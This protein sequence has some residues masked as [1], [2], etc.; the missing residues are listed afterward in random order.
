MELS[1]YVGRWVK[2][3]VSNGYYYQGLI[4]NVDEDSVTLRD[5]NNKLVT[6]KFN[7]ILNV[8]EVEN[9]R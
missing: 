2:I 8:R 1:A 9:G 6:L 7:D 5:K 4:L 3:D